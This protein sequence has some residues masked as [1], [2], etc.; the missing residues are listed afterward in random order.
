MRE[1][2]GTVRE[3]N[4]EGES[5]SVREREKERQRENKGLKEI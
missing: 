3:K 4:L 5:E 1:G 2:E